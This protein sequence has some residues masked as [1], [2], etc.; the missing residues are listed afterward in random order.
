M[1]RNDHRNMIYMQ[2]LSLSHHANGNKAMMNIF[3]DRTIRNHIHD[4]HMNDRTI[5]GLQPLA[6]NTKP[7]VMAQQPDMEL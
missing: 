5:R 3:R 6:V 7:M 1:N 2:G 4:D